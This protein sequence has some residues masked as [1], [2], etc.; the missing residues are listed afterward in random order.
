SA[1]TRPLRQVAA[2]QQG[3]QLFPAGLQVVA[4]PASDDGKS[5]SLVKPPR[6]LIVFL[7]FEEDGADAAPRQMAKM[8]PQEF[9][10][11]AATPMA[12]GHRDRKYL[13]PVGPDPGDRKA[14]DLAPGGQA[15]NQRV[16]LGQH[17]LE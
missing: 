8:G 2:H 11:Q 5:A 13:G 1:T 15:V 17:G 4:F 9:A 3:V 12:L 6:R 10:R 7:D 14:D 16:A